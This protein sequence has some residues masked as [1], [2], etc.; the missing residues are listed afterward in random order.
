MWKIGDKIVNLS[1]ILTI[2]EIVRTDVK[3]GIPDY[4]CKNKDDEVIT[5]SEQVLKE[6]IQVQ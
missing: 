3:T 6:Y 2:E 4:V 1:N 5:L